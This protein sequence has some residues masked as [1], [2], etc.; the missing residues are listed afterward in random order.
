MSRLH[1]KIYKIKM[2]KKRNKTTDKIRMYT[3]RLSVF[4]LRANLETKET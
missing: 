1:F 2:E 4:K 3:V